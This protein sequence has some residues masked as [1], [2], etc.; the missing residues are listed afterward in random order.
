MQMVSQEYRREVLQRDKTSRGDGVDKSV[1]MKVLLCRELL[2]RTAGVG[3]RMLQGRGW[4]TRG[5]KYQGRSGI[6][7]ICQTP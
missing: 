2:P 4:V 5:K 3:K 7:L 6:F 1:G